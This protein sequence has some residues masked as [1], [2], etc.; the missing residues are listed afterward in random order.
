MTEEP[1]LLSQLK[2]LGEPDEPAPSE[3]ETP[4]AQPLGLGGESREIDGAREGIRELRR[5][6]AGAIRSAFSSDQEP[7]NEERRGA[8]TGGGAI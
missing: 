7:V 6:A 2:S 5:R 4:A 8:E 3:F 1:D